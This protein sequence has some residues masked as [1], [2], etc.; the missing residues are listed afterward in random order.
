MIRSDEIDRTTSRCACCGTV[1][2]DAGLCSHHGVE[3]GDDWAR[4]NRVMCDFI[5]RGIVGLAS[6][7][8]VFVEAA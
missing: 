7:D 1:I 6:A 4:E 2:G 3:Y 8:C 5:H